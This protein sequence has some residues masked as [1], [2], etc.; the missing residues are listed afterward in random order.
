MDR[1][2]FAKAAEL[3][4][5]GFCQQTLA[6]DSTGRDCSPIYPDAVCFCASG[7]LYRALYDTTEIGCL[8]VAWF[9]RLEELHI[10]LSKA[11]GH[12]VKTMPDKHIFNW[13]DANDAETVAAQLEQLSKVQDEQ[14]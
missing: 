5:K 10:E 9:H 11:I 13:N 3:I 12:D 8:G 2:I 7:A 1:Q 14:S 4:R 6:K